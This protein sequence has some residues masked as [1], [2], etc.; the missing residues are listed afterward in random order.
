MRLSGRSTHPEC[1][2]ADAVLTARW[3]GPISTYTWNDYV[4]PAWMVDMVKAE[5]LDPYGILAREMLRSIRDTAV[6]H[7]MPL[8]WTV[9]DELRFGT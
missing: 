6:P 2:L 4:F 8:E 7:R 5:N 9:E 1:R 3:P